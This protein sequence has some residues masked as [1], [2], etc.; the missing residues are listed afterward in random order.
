M[1]FLRSFLRRHL[2]GK[3]VIPSPNVFSGY[4]ACLAD[5]LAR[6]HLSLQYSFRDLPLLP[7]QLN[8][9]SMGASAEESGSKKHL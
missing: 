6:S 2:E 9:A 1:E 8:D 3:P 7:F 5:Q 4:E